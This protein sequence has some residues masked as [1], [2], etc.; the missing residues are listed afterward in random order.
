[1]GRREPNRL[2]EEKGEQEFARVPDQAL[3]AMGRAIDQ[4]EGAVR[5]DPE[6][7]RHRLVLKISAVEP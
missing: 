6:A 4:Q 3:G 1:M 5:G 7:R 2:G